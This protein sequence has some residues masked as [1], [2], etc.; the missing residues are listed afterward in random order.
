MG[1][2]LVAEQALAWHHS[3]GRGTEQSRAWRRVGPG[4]GEEPGAALTWGRGLAAPQLRAGRGGVQGPEPRERGGAVAPEVWHPW[5]FPF[6]AVGGLSPNDCPSLSLN[7][8]SKSTC[9]AH[10]APL[11]KAGYSD[12]AIHWL[13]RGRRDSVQCRPAPR[14]DTSAA[15]RYR[16]TDPGLAHSPALPGGGG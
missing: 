4:C 11:D 9:V 10:A 2:G 8:S 6:R 13:S 15:L 5:K 16:G 7:L 12:K 14:A 3:P 1:R